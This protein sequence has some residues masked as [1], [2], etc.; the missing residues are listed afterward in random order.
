MRLTN[1]GSYGGRA[2]GE[3]AVAQVVEW[4]RQGPRAAK[5]VA[6][7]GEFRGQLASHGSGRGC[8]N[9][10]WRDADCRLQLA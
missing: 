1:G 4:C 8:S 2:G 5:Y 7:D 3:V 6:N 9:D 10:N